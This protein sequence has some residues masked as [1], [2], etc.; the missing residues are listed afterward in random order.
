M[1]Q[2]S[3]YE[4]LH[5]NIVINAD[6][7]GG[8]DSDPKI[9]AAGYGFEGIIGIPG[10]LS[11][12]QIRLAKAHGAGVIQSL[13]GLNTTAPLRNITS[14]VAPVA[15]KLSG[16]SRKRPTQ[17][18]MDAMPI[19][20]SH[21]IL[22]S[23]VQPENFRIH[24][25]TGEIVT[26]LYVAQNPN[27]DFN[28]RQTVVAFGYFGNRLPTN[29]PEAVHPEQFEVVK[30]KIPLQLITPEG[31][32]NGTG[33]SHKSSNPY[34]S[35]NGPTLV[36]AKLSKLSLAGD[37]APVSLSIGAN[38]GVE[39]YG[40]R[41]N[42]Y[43]LRMFTSGGFSPD[44]VSGFEPQQFEK[45]FQ[46]TAKGCDNQEVTI[47]RDGQWIRVKGGQLKV[48][49][50]ADLGDGLNADPEY[51]YS[52][53]HDNQFDLIVKASSEQAI[54]SLKEVILPKPQ[55]GT[56][57]PIYNPGGP[58]TEPLA[59]YNYTEPSPGQTL[60]IEF[61]LKDPSTVSWASQDLND[62]DNAD[63]LAVAFRLQDP[64]TGEWRLTSSSSVAKELVDS[65]SWALIDVPFATNPDDS[66]VVDVYELQHAY[67]ND[68]LYITDLD[69]I[70]LLEKIG[71]INEGAVFTAYDKPLEG[72]DPIW[73]MASK[74]G[75]HAVTSS[76]T[77]REQ[78]LDQGWEA[79][80]IA[81]YS[82]NF[83]NSSFVEL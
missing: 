75:Q 43:R 33:L 67:F 54:K 73:Q 14:G 31:L 56:H 3:T 18:Y 39:Y 49:G 15:I 42:L 45:F 24:L 12:N 22:P 5:R 44:G 35:F 40:E 29:H 16:F 77:Q 21:P 1:S 36:G 51:T 6:I 57:S 52:E 83:P 19:E 48:M 71:Y 79:E 34:D 55:L 66:Y 20:F 62:Y 9:L 80:G 23:T 30:S 59:E 38:H 41:E 76:V 32:V 68:S 47:D 70:Q 25:N 74:K 60:A 46:L 26:P 78:W 4:Q 53:D 37:Y 28:E 8:V 82:V 17:T 7:Y 63:D 50:I 13:V 27:Y 81:F 58:G 11:E 69:Q 72:L 10:L 64:I 65:E 2:G 61:A